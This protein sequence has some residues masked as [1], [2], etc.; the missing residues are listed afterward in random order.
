MPM[1]RIVV[2][3]NSLSGGGAERAANLLADALVRNGFEVFLI[4]INSG[5]PDFITP[6]CKI[7][8]VGREWKSGFLPTLLAIIEFRQL[9]IELNPTYLLINCE[10]P[11]LFSISLPKKIQKIV[12]EHT[13]NPWKGRRPLG[14]LVR[15][16]LFLQGSSW[17]F[18]SKFIDPWPKFAIKNVEFIPNLLTPTQVV[19]ESDLFPR[20]VFVGRFSS[21]KGVMIFLEIVKQSGLKGLMIGEGLLRDEITEKIS[22]GN[23]DITLTGQ[24]KNP[25]SKI[26]S[27]DIVIIPS[28]YEGDG[29]VA[30]EALNNHLSIIVS[31]IPAFQRLE[32]SDPQYCESVQ[33]FCESVQACIS[34]PGD[35]RKHSDRTRE[36]LSGRQEERILETWLLQKLYS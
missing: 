18:V 24:L 23:L 3:T 16:I 27:Q 31:K 10:L 20:L 30:L 17:V 9:I 13:T 5:E 22:E 26:A 1:H 28:E 32:L 36:E 21:E 25:W 33:E 14:F 8:S 12:I 19:K 34:N 2:V 11:E 15:T 7:L 35:F 4:P 6:N 29:L